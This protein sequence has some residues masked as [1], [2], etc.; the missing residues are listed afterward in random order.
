MRLMDTLEKNFDPT[1][2]DRAQQL[3]YRS[4]EL[5]RSCARTLHAEQDWSLMGRDAARDISVGITRVAE[6]A[7]LCGESAADLDE[8]WK[9]LFREAAV[10][11]NIDI[12]RKGITG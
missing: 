7:G 2:S 8:F 9:Q 3:A 10:D 4:V 11:V 1:D 12:V 6:M 5:I